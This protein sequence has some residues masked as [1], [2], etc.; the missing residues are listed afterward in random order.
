MEIADC[1]RSFFDIRLEMVN[2]FVKL[3]MTA[4]DQ[5]GEV[6]RERASLAL[7]KRAQPGFERF[8]QCAISGEKTNIEQAD[9]KLDI[10]FIELAAF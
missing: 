10:L 7:I 1:A 3:A 2:G 6:A 8:E 5:F 4:A 9:V